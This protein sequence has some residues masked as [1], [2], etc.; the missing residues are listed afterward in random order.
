MHERILL[1]IVQFYIDPWFTV[2]TVLWTIQVVCS[3]IHSGVDD[4]FMYM[5]IATSQIHLNSKFVYM[6]T[7]GYEFVSSEQQL[8]AFWWVDTERLGTSDESS[9][10]HDKLV[11][12]VTFGGTYGS[13]HAFAICLL[14]TEDMVPHFWQQTGVASLSFIGHWC[15]QIC[16]PRN[17]TINC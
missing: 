9:C 5:H 12:A 8:A 10:Q 15:S 2:A 4:S 17:S 3:L 14:N 1:I 11:L 7:Y 13:W 6:C 16:L